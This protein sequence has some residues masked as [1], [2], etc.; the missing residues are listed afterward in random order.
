LLVLALLAGIAA[1]VAPNI[2][3]LHRAASEDEVVRTTQ[4]VLDALAQARLTA[5]DRGTRVRVVV[6]PAA[7]RV[8]TYTTD[9][10]EWRLLGTRTLATGPSVVFA[11]A[12]PRVRFTFDPAGTASGDTVTVRGIDGV[13]AV[14]VDPWTGVAHAQS[15]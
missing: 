7:A 1:V 10:D 9:G 6:D 4:G 8:W 15:R 2:A 12:G 3:T 14:S 11:A 5:L 13:R